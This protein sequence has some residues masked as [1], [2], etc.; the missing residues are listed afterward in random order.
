MSWHIHSSA[1]FFDTDAYGT[2]TDSPAHPS[3]IIEDA[4]SLDDE[5]KI[6][7]AYVE[8]REEVASWFFNTSEWDDEWWDAWIDKLNEIM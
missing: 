7:E 4:L 2:S 8:F 1:S 5:Q 6:Y 3:E